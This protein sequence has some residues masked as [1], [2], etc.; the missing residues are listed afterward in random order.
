MERLTGLDGAFLSFESTTTHLHILGTLVFDPT[1]VPGGV[2]FRRVRDLIADRMRLVPPFGKRMVEVPLG[3][4]HASM[5]DD[6]A[7][8]L[9]YHVRRACLPSPG[10]TRELCQL[11]ADIASRPLDRRRPLWEFHVV[12]GLEDGHFALVTKVHHSIIDGVSGAEIL[13]AFF[14]LQP[15]PEPVPRRLFAEG[16]DV[17]APAG[18][19]GPERASDD[20]PSVG[21]GTGTELPNDL[22]RWRH[23][24]AGIPGHLDAVVRTVS[25]TVQTARTL[26]ARR[27]DRRIASPPVPFE[28]PRTSINRAISPH[29]RVAFAEMPLA[30]VRRVGEVLGGTTNDVVLAAT[31]GA[32]RTFFSRRNERPDG[33]LVAMVP[34]SVRTEDERGTLGNRVTAM[35]VSLATEVEDPIARLD[36]IRAGVRGAKDQSRSIDPDLY[37]AWAEAVLPAIST[38]VSRLVSNLKVFDRLAPVFNLIVSNVPGPDFPL[39][40]AGARLVAMYPVGP[41]IEGAG[42]NVTVFSYLETVYVGVQ[43]CWDLAPDVA[44]VASGMEDSLQELVR[45]ANRRDRPVPWWHAELP[46]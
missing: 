42:V 17:R 36:E 19:T 16:S 28:A 18:P 45:A 38:R 23:A 9:D 24:L 11:V 14:D 22:D 2:D 27:R 13:A 4:Q 41:I 1:G 20:E 15:E 7:F 5:V 46:A 34:V 43:A 3:L 39:Y 26:G 31:A 40:L 32:M 8:D 25:N 30:D 33:S 44:T 37:A 12:E 6:D 35:F 10:G 21:A 29:R